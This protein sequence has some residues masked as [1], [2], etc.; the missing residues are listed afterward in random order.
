MRN[1]F[2][3]NYNIFEL[4]Q[5][6]ISKIVEVTGCEVY[7]E[8]GVLQGLNIKEVSKFCERCI[9][10]DIENNLIFTNFE[11]Y[12]QTTD[13]FFK[14]FNDRVD[15]VF[16]DADHDFN[17]VIKDFQNSLNLLNEHGII[18]LHDTD[19]MDEKYLPKSFCG[20]SYKIID[21]IKENYP[22]LDLITLPVGVAGL[23]IVNKNKDRRALKFLKI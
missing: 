6:L 7:L 8:L 20:D 3:Y 2:A 13:D 5:T 19:P 21:W 14:S 18:F 15:I 10:V 11:F 23:T 4:H 1:K 22:E 17:Q 9:G 16:I 12:Q